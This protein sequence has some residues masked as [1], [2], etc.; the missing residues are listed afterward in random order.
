MVAGRRVISDCRHQAGESIARRFEGA[1]R[2]IW[3]A[4]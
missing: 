3:G 1:M 4:G 2:A